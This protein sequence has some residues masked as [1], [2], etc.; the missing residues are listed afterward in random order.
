MSKK[1]IK[2]QK[3]FVKRMQSVILFQKNLIFMI[4]KRYKEK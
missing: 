3:V 1:N 2:E 4:K